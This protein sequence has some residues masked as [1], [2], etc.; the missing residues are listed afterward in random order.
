MGVEYALFR[1]DNKTAFDLGKGWWHEMAD[2]AFDPAALLQHI[3]FVS[4]DWGWKQI[5]CLILRD[6]VLDFVEGARPSEI[7]C[8]TDSYYAGEEEWYEYTWTYDRYI[9]EATSM[10]YDHELDKDES[11]WVKDPVKFFRDCNCPRFQYVADRKSWWGK[12]PK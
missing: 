4:R 2:L 3:V 10:W 1:K 5:N 7:K 9:D 12:R 8:L 11:I 6:R